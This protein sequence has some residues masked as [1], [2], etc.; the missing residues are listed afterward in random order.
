MN[1]DEIKARCE[2]ATLG[3]WSW[4]GIVLRQERRYGA[5]LLE[6]SPNV[7]VV[8]VNC[9]FIAHAREDVPDLVAEVE[10]LRN[11]CKT[12]HSIL[13]KKWE[14]PRSAVERAVLDALGES[15][16][17]CTCTE[18]IRNGEIGSICKAHGST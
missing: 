16:E 14:R 4:Q 8:E 17:T 11:V 2:A 13:D 12:A 10:R 3:P 7:L 18:D 15:N 1:L 6:L 5:M 9:E